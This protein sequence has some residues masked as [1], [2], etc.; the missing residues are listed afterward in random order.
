M[1]VREIGDR[2]GEGGA[3]ANLGVAYRALSEP[4]RARVLLEQALAIGREIEDPEII[5]VASQTLQKLGT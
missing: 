3:L 2:R 5:R 4:A 1:I